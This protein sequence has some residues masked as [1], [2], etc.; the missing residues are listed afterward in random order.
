M[1]TP[2]SERHVRPTRY[3]RCSNERTQSHMAAED[4]KLGLLKSPRVAIIV[5]ALDEEA[6]IAELCT[7]LR[8][9]IERDA[10]DAEVVIVD[11]GSTDRTR[12]VAEHRA[13]EWRLLRVVSHGRRRGKTEAL[14]S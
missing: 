10:L 13:Q 7:E 12:E 11:D 1:P 5:P 2:R 4:T 14:L 8:T 3:G 9:M 6:N